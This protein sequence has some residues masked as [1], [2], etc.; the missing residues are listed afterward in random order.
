VEDHRRHPAGAITSYVDDV[1]LGREAAAVPDDH[2]GQPADQ[3]LAT[4]QGEPARRTSAVALDRRAQP[5]RHSRVELVAANGNRLD[6]ATH[7]DPAGCLVVLRERDPLEVDQ[8]V[9]LERGY[10]DWR[11]AGTVVT[12]KL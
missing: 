9:G 8:L 5:L 4:R 6:R 1:V 12:A 11:A 7:R 2:P 3:H 10:A